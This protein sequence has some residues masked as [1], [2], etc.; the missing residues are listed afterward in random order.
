MK[1]LSILCFSILFVVDL[2][3]QTVRLD[4][5]AVNVRNEYLTRLAKELTLA[6]GPGYYRD[7]V[8][9]VI[10]GVDVFCCKGNKYLEYNACDGRRYYTVVFPTKEPLIWDYTSKALIWEDNG[11]PLSIF[12][13][14]AEISRDFIRKSYT[15]WLE[16]GIKEEDQ[17]PYWTSPPRKEGDPVILY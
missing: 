17:C 7:S 9:P 8:I 5:M 6:F 10:T 14:G 11:Q 4:T 15:E 12:F 2:C 13:G 3:A 1:R 16:Q